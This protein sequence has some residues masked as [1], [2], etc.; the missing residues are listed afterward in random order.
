ML[1][2]DKICQERR[3]ILSEKEK[4]ETE[5]MMDFLQSFDEEDFDEDLSE[6]R[7]R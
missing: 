2:I 1:A 5:E 3:H 4:Q 7:V 6:A